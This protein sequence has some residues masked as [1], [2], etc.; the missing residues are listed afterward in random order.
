MHKAPR[1][2]DRRLILGLLSYQPLTDPDSLLEGSSQRSQY[3]GSQRAS[4]GSLDIDPGV[5]G[6]SGL[7]HW[8]NKHVE[9]SLLV[10]VCSVRNKR[11]LPHPGIS[12]N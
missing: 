7:I 4:S 2:Y 6:E 12:I 8:G 5:R 9:G 11:V 1:R 3:G 10:V